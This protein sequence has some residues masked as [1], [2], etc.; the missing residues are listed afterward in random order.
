V[1]YQDIYN[2]IGN[3]Y[4]ELLFKEFEYRNISKKIKNEKDGSEIT[5]FEY[6]LDR[7]QYD[8][9]SKSNE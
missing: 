4:D 2:Y 5:F 9:F 3:I 1:F 7:M 6:L 8:D